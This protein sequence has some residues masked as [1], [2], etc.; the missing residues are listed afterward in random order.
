MNRALREQA[1]RHRLLTLLSEHLDTLGPVHGEEPRE[2]RAVVRRL[3]LQ[4]LKSAPPE[5][6]SH[7]AAGY[8]HGCR[9][10]TCQGWQDTRLAR[11]NK[12]HPRARSRGL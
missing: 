7:G 3:R 2:Y 12:T 11:W 10:E 9:C 4:T 1:I 6:K 5:I 8:A